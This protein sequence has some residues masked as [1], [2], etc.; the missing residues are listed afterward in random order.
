[1]HLQVSAGKRQSCGDDMLDCCAVRALRAG[2]YT[3]LA[4]KAGALSKCGKQRSKIMNRLSSGSTAARNA[5]RP[6]HPQGCSEGVWLEANTWQNILLLRSSSLCSKDFLRAVPR[7]TI[8]GVA[9]L[10][11]KS[12]SSCH[13]SDKKGPPGSSSRPAALKLITGSTFGEI[14]RWQIS[15]IGFF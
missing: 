9:T 4:L 11:C 6:T 5:E 3:A 14:L 12:R 15:V 10:H 1:M 7:Q 2:S 8:P 13:A